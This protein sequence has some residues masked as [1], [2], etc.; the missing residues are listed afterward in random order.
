MCGSPWRRVIVGSMRRHG[1]WLSVPCLLGCGGSLRD[2]A[3]PTWRAPVLSGERQQHHPLTLTIEGPRSSETADGPNP[4]LDFRLSVELTT[5][6]GKSLV[7]PGYFAGDGEGGATGDKWRAHFNP[8][9]VGEHSYKISFRA[10][11]AVAIDLDPGAGAPLPPDG[12]SGKFTVAPSDKRAPG[13]LATG[14]LIYAGDHYLRTGGDGKIWLKG[15]VDSPEDLLGY[16]G[17]VHTEDRGGVKKDFLHAF[18]PHVAD[19]RAGAPDW[20]GGAGKGIIG[21]LNYLAG[22]HVN[23]IYFLACNIGGDGD[24]T[25]PYTGYGDRFHFDNAKLAQWETVFAHAT[26][27][28]IALHFVLSENENY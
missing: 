20:A 25:W 1:L 2:G 4:F 15:G 19:R 24:N 23:S 5:P 12:V 21:M 9:E 3:L 8:S 22:A 11:K 28:G 13:F 6:A 18:R 17:F 26:R 7:V 10:G 16:A 14:K 27:L